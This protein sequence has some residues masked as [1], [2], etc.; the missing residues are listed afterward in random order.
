MR[1]NKYI[2]ATSSALYHPQVEW[3]AALDVEKRKHE[4]HRMR[5]E[6]VGVRFFGLFSLRAN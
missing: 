4:A 5:G 6:E 2:E 1:Q 3:R